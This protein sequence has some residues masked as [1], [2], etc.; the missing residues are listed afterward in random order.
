MAYREGLAQP[1]GLEHNRNAALHLSSRQ[2]HLKV[3]IG[4]T[5]SRAAFSAR[6]ALPLNATVL[7]HGGAAV[8][9]AADQSAGAST[10]SSVRA[11]AAS[12]CICGQCCAS[13]TGICAIL[14]RTSLC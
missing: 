3:D 6:H 10:A 4:I 8:S 7:F 13:Y 2:Q 1:L 14:G 5:A 9:R 11:A 12:S